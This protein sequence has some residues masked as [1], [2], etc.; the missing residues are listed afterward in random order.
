MKRLFSSLLI[1]AVLILGV[2][3]CSSDS[4]SD[5]GSKSENKDK[6]V[7]GVTN[8]LS[9]SLAELGQAIHNGIKLAIKK[10]N[11]EGGLN[12]KQIEI[13]EADV[14][15]ASAAKS[16]TEKLIKDKKA[17]VIIG[18]YGSSIALAVSEVAARNKIPYFETVSTAEQLTQ[19]GYDGVYRLSPSSSD[20]AKVAFNAINGPISEALKKKP[21][22]LK[23]AIVHEDTDYGSGFAEYLDTFMDEAGIKDS[24]ILTEP[25]SAGTND[26]TSLILKLRDAKPDVVVAVSYLQDAI[27]FTKQSKELGVNYPVL[28]GGG[29][30]WGQPGFVEALGSVT[31][32]VFDIEYPPLP[33]N[34]NLDALKGI[35]EYIPL[36]EKEY[37]KAPNGVYSHTAYGMTLEILNILEKSA[38]L[39]VEDVKK[40]AYEYET[41]WWNTAAGWGAKFIDEDGHTGQDAYAEPYLTQW[42]NG[43]LVIVSPEEASVEKPLIP[44]PNW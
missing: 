1:L 5:S 30:G 37:G 16:E 43:N 14:P 8:P 23:V 9:G 7:I 25:Y 22:D 3:G 6:V 44:K 40:S 4:S 35:N 36:Y 21:S 34:S 29:G 12:G 27:L 18:T 26:M 2:V 38:S 19:R 17:D 42:R 33:P 20:F 31:E 15:E 32:G 24:L 13:V 10:K 39:S 41:P 28:L 11:E